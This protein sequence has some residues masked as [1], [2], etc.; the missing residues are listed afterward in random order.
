MK[1]NESPGKKNPMS[2]PVSANTMTHSAISPYGLNEFDEL[3]DVDAEERDQVR[4]RGMLTL[5][6]IGSHMRGLLADVER[7]NPFARRMRVVI[8]TTRHT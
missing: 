6:N 3:F 7:V 2:S 1:S 8:R 4:H 5:A